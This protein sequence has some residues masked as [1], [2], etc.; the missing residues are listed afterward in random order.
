M[1]KNDDDKASKVP[2]PPRI[3]KKKEN[4]IKAREEMERSL[5]QQRATGSSALSGFE[6]EEEEDVYDV[7]DE[8]T[9]A[10]VVEKRRSGKDFVVDDS[11]CPSFLLA[12]C[13][14][15]ARCSLAR[16]CMKFDLNSYLYEDQAFPCEVP[17]DSI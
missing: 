11:K 5:K 4:E 17:K 8:Q 1:P 16:V 9:Y 2:S 14:S 15:L 12:F 10:D 3:S 13:Y 7:V 6:L